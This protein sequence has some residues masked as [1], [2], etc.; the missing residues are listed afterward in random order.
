MSRT[1]RRLGIVALPFEA[2]T[3]FLEGTR[4]GP[5]AILRE[6]ADLDTF[7]LSLGRDPFHGI[8]TIVY[9]PHS[10]DLK[11]P[12][13]QQSLAAGKVNTILKSGGFPLCLGGEHTAS[14]GPIHELRKLGD[15]SIVQLDA[16]ADL[17]DE[18]EGNR[19]SHACVMRRAVEAGCSLIGIG[20][21]AMCEEEARFVAERGL[22][23]IEAREASASTGWYSLLD[24]LPGSVY[25]TIDMDVF[26][27]S[28]VSAVGTPEPGGLSY[29][30]VIRFLTHLFKTKDV[31]AADIVEL[32]PTN[33]DGASV[34]AAA[35]L[36]GL[37]ASMISI[38]PIPQVDKDG[39][40]P[41]LST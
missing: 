37:I 29:E 17:R 22:N 19:F 16:H 4:D 8:Q 7:D 40:D 15:L 12:R 27:P 6:L 26:D 31:V 13:E 41:L 24:R 3:S 39:A 5:E 9:H 20:I 38:P 34:R 35:R 2:S 36:V 18:Y 10:A 23:I 11:D 25:L 14:I 1:Q 30:V 28:E 21:R 32:R 33:G